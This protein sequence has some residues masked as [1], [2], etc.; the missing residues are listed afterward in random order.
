[1]ALDAYNAQ[2]PLAYYEVGTAYSF[3]QQ[4][5]NGGSNPLAVTNEQ[6]KKFKDALADAKKRNAFNPESREWG[7]MTRDIGVVVNKYRGEHLS[8][9]EVMFESDGKYYVYKYAAEKDAVL[10]DDKE[11]VSIIERKIKATGPVAN[12]VTGPTVT[13][14][15]TGPAVD[16]V[17]GPAK[18]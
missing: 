9:L 17:T 12:T 18:E 4:K 13:N 3:Y 16:K 11:Y 8:V 2:Y 6:I 15:V 7:A 14:S 5:N 1:M 10:M